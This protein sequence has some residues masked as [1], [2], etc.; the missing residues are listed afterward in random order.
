[1]L[2]LDPHTLCFSAAGVAPAKALFLS[3][4]RRSRSVSAGFVFSKAASWDQLPELVLGVQN[5]KMPRRFS[6]GIPCF[7]YSPRYPIPPFPWPPRSS[8]R[9]VRNA[10][11]NILR[12]ERGKIVTRYTGGKATTAQR[13]DA[14]NHRPVHPLRSWRFRTIVRSERAHALFPPH[15]SVHALRQSSRLPC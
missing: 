1:L 15:K 6:R 2:Q 3:P 7:A 13:P 9:N 11:A 4:P 14:F 12:T 10:P 5:A 8:Y